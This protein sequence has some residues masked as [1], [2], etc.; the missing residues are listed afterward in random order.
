MKTTTT[1]KNNKVTGN[2]VLSVL[3]QRLQA[4]EHERTALMETIGIYK[5]NR[6]NFDTRP[7]VAGRPSTRAPRKSA[8]EEVTAIIRGF[9]GKKFTMNDIFAEIKAQK[10]DIDRTHA[11]NAV[12]AL[13]ESIE[14]VQAGIGRRIAVYRWRPN[15]NK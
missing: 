13:K 2:N 7:I 8:V 6:S 1:T 9:K 14:I 15:Q 3:Q 5:G 12:T 4:V 10:L 11:Y